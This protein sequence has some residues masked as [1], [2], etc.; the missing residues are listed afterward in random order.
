MNARDGPYHAPVPPDEQRTARQDVTSSLTVG[1]SIAAWSIGAFVFYLIAGRALGP[2]QYGLAAALQSVIVVVA[3]PIIALQWSVARVVASGGPEA[4]AGAMGTYKRALARGT[5]LAAALAAIATVVV[6]AIASTGHDV[7]TAALVLTFAAIVLHVPLLVAEGALQG[8][9]RYAGLAWSYAAS[10]VLR[11]PLLVLL[12]VAPIGDVN[13]TVLAVALAV[14][15][16]AAW[17]VGLTRPGLRTA[18]RPSATDW[19]DFTRPLP[20][21]AIGLGGIAVLQNVDVIAAKLSLGGVDAGLFGAAAVLAKGLLVVP[22]A[23]TIVLLPRVAEQEARG[24]PTGSFLAVG[25][26]VMAVTGILAMAVAAV[27]E[28]PVMTI[29]FGSAFEGAASLLVPFLG[30][31]T[32]LGALLILVNHHVARSDHRFVWV[33]GALALVQITLLALFGHSAGMIITIDAAVA[34]VGLLIHEVIYAGT[35]ESMI[36]GAGTQAMN[37]IR[38]LR[39]SSKGET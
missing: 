15:I 8:S 21:I 1:A 16:G 6:I 20:A 26:L 31:T 10:G 32:M 3:V 5:G 35:S 17:A 2:A 24:K 7:P 22:Q 36:S 29:A 14:G 39:Q 9:H 23:L 4:Q 11:A 30:A 28:G 25:V 37:I 13:A 34:G 12:L 38:R 19:S 18:T 27:I 33:V